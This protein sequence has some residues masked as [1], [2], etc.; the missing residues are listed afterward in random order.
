MKH[1]GICL[2]TADDI[3]YIPCKKEIF[4]DKHFIQNP[5]F[6]VSKQCVFNSVFC[7]KYSTILIAENFCEIHLESYLSLFLSFFN[8]FVWEVFLDKKEYK[9]AKQYTKVLF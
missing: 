7:A 3:D 5:Q 2:H 8:R 9:L 1:Y 6:F 4:N